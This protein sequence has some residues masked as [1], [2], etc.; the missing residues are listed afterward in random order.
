MFVNCR[1][2]VIGDMR[3]T[4]YSQC[5][6]C[7]MEKC[8]VSVLVCRQNRNFVYEIEADGIDYGG[9]VKPNGISMSLV[10]SGC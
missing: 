5:V 2:F 4:S 3:R 1:G 6:C 7:K 9:N 10:E 8:A